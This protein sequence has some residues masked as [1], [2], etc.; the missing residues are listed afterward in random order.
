MNSP[1][2]AEISEILNTRMYDPSIV[3]T[4]EAYL[5]SQ[6]NPTNPQPYYFDANRLLVKQYKFF[7][8]L[9][10]AENMALI[11]LLALIYGSCEGHV[12]F[13]A[14]QCLVP[15]YSKKEEPFVLISR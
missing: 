11:Q 12:D 1:S 15:E 14:L 13:G 8:H 9:L 5:H 3:P 4:L 6:A 7:P 2:Y 10:N